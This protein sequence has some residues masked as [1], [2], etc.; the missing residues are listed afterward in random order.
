MRG[1]GVG[2]GTEMDGVRSPDEQD[3]DDLEEIWERRRDNER[4]GERS[5]LIGQQTQTKHTETPRRRNKGG[6][7]SPP[8]GW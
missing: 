3:G 8:E 1:G 6:H 4:E 2:G 7:L 5:A